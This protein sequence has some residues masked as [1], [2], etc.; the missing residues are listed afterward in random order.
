MYDEAVG[1][2]QLHAVRL[3]DIHILAPGFDLAGP[4]RK[5][6]KELEHR[7]VCNGIPEVIA[8]YESVQ[9]F[10]DDVKEWVQSGKSGILSVTHHPSPMAVR[11]ATRRLAAQLRAARGPAWHRPKAGRTP[12]TGPAAWR[13]TGSPPAPPTPPAPP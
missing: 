2:P 8:V 4:T 12:N 5:A 3:H 1:N 11:H 10:H 7:V 6:V 13:L 9:T